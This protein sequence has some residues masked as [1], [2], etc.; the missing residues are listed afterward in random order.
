MTTMKHVD[1]IAKHNYSLL[2]M[3]L[4]KFLL[5]IECRRLPED[6]CQCH[7][8]TSHPHQRDKT[9]SYVIT[10]EIEESEPVSELT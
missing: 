4:M 5:K 8:L 9:E 7:L 2:M 1:A 3:F 10:P 6:L